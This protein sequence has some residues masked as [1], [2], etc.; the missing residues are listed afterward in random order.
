V[1]GNARVAQGDSAGAEQAFKL[2]A[3]LAQQAK[4]EADHNSGMN[5]Q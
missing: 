4:T 2:A 3:D 5:L 1:I